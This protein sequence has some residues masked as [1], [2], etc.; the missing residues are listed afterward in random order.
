M[1]GMEVAT[2]ANYNIAVIWMIL[3][4]GGLGMVRHGQRLSSKVIETSH[5]FNPIGT[6]SVP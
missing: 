1:N 3:N 6:G 2:A 5:A 4:D